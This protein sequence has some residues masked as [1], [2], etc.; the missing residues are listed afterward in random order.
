MAGKRNVAAALGGWS[1]RH[2]K[3]AVF[4]WLVFVV[5]AT[6]VGGAVGQK[7][8]T[9][10]Q[11]GVGSS[12]QALQ[13]LQDAGLS[14]PASE[15]VLVHSASQNAD[16]AS[17]RTAVDAV[18]SGVQGTGQTAPIQ[19]PYTA[20]LIS[21]D[22]H[23]ALVVFDIVGDP[24]KAADHAQP[25]LD[26][27]A[28]VRAQ[29]PDIKFDEFGDAS[30][31]K[32]LN[33]SL[34]KDFKRAEWTAVPLAFGILLAAFGALIA[35]ALPVLLAVTAFVAA[36]G[37]LDLVSHSMPVA[38]T[39]TSVM[40]L[41]GLAVGVDY[42]LFYLR[43]ERQER[44]A[45]RSPQ[46]ALSVAAA[47]SGH[48]VLVSGVTVMVAMAGMF[49]TGMHIFDGFALASILV[50]A[51][52]M[53]GSVTV[54]PALL[55]MLGDRIDWGRRKSRRHGQARQTRQ[56]RAAAANGGRVWNATMAKVLNHPKPFAAL[57]VGALVVL[58]IPALGMKTQSLNVNQLLP[59]TSPLVQT[60]NE[61]SADFPASPAPGM[62]VVKTPD[63]NSPAVAQAVDAFKTQA[64]AAGAL[65]DGP[66]QVTPYP[67]QHVLKILFP[68]AG[69]DH[70]TTAVNAITKIGDT[71]VPHTFGA[72]PHTT[73]A[74]GGSLALS[75]D[76]N[77]QLDHSLLP[78]FVFVVSVTF[79]LMLV[80]FRSW[81]IAATA[82]VLNLLSTA[83]AYGVMVAVFQH[84]WGARLV[85]TTAV[86]AIEAWIPLFVF[87]VLFGL[88]MD[89]H[90]FVVS[91]IREARER[92]L[93]TKD[94]VAH[95]LRVTAGA[96]TSAAAI[97]VAVFAVFGTLDMQDFKQLG[98][99]L[100]IAILLDATVI[101]VVLL[102]TVMILLGE[103]NWRDRKTAAP[104]P[105]PR[106]E[107]GGPVPIE[108]GR[109][110]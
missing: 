101:R 6:V 77:R 97:M 87:V 64:A 4:G 46:E 39:S 98:V 88:S 106:P 35:A 59:A 99:G 79:L 83:A 51:I 73:A 76:F 41:M 53:L 86:G 90:V 52:A 28:K 80:A 26:A 85:G 36:L 110:R 95:G 22:R 108:A 89:Y 82:I 105:L 33:E 8:L 32:W 93:S 27:V 29:N 14:D 75:T 56:A 104:A 70:D 47:T 48:S 60:Y 102:P 21:K 66:V 24:D 96:I 10:A 50:V 18:V 38:S 74:T 63:V 103:R 54:L 107:A 91:R 78:V 45:G 42:C 61:I 68:V 5:L 58:A 23:S 72:L 57:A 84:G 67:A 43:R 31:Q 92:G 94:A 25:I 100:A 37:L 109:L 69:R 2:R 7:S 9:D 65:G 71:I 49:L 17:F 81:V 1:A 11:N 13:M 15:M 16:A 44:A 12:A 55:S 40:L 62:I 34:G 3:T 19:S 20:G 30:G